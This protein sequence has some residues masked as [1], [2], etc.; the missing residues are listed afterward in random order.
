MLAAAQAALGKAAL[1]RATLRD[2]WSQG[3]ATTLE[4]AVIFT[5]GQEENITR[6]E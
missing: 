3:Q 2:L 6:A 4:Q 1:D 5:L